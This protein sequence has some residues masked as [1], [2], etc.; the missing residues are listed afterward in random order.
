MSKFVNS[1]T[2]AIRRK[3]P[4][5]QRFPQWATPE[6]RFHLAKLRLSL[7]GVC[8]KGH[9]G[10]DFRLHPDHFI[11]LKPK[12]VWI[13]EPTESP[14]IDPNTG[15]PRKDKFL[16]GWKSVP[17]VEYQPELTNAY[18]QLE[19]DLIEHWKAEDRAERDELL[20]LERAQIHGEKGAFGRR[21]DPVER[22]VF[23]AGCPDHFP[24]ALGTPGHLYVDVSRPKA[25]PALSKNKRRKIR[26]HGHEAPAKVN[27]LCQ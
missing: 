23:M 2:G 17:V 24:K 27:Q 4:K 10:C 3:P 6:R 22:D 13:A 9:H 25:T 12:V 19:E 14:W 18:F 1:T 21:F 11:N 16:R 15:L 5:E 7:L 20:K 26:R 8:L